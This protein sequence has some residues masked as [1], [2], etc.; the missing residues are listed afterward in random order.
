[1]PDIECK[2]WAERIAKLK[3]KFCEMQSAV[4]VCQGTYWFLT[5]M[6]GLL[7]LVMQEP[8]NDLYQKALEMTTKVAMW[9]K[10][11]TIHLL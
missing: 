10:L 5:M 4:K 7:L 1:M 2:F 8:H 9:A 3:S 6:F 11:S